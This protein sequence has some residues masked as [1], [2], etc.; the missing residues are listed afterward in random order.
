MIIRLRQS[1]RLNTNL[2][3]TN[4]LNLAVVFSIVIKVVGSS[5]QSLLDQRRQT[6]LLIFQKAELKAEKATQRLEEV[7]RTFEAAHVRGK[8]IRLQTIQTIEQDK[9]IIQEQLKKD[10][11]RL[12]ERGNQTIQLECQRITQAISYQ[13]SNLAVTSAENTLL[14]IL[15]VQIPPS[16]KQKELNEMY[17]RKTF[18]H[19]NE[20]NHLKAISNIEVYR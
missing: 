17:I 13:I 6:I 15:K 14:K 18:C 16:T 20:L 12:Q 2:F 19:L 3:E 7:Q 11:R 8:E 4:I 10:L 5:L 1:F 9:I